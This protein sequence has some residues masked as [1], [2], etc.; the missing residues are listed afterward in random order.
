MQAP[1]D[2]LAKAIIDATL[3]AYCDVAL[4]E[5]VSADEL[6]SDAVVDPKADGSV[7]RTRG[8]LGRMATEPC[9]IEAYSSNISK[10][11]VDRCCARASWHRAQ[12]GDDRLLWIVTPG[13]ARSVLDCWNLRRRGWPEGVFVGA[14]RREP[15]VV[16]L[17]QL[18]RS[19][20]TLL[21][22]LMSRGVDLQRAI[23]DVG[24]LSK[25]CWERE[26]VAKLLVRVGPE[27]ARMTG[28]P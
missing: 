3:G 21:L 14:H 20:S 2:T 24:A 16:V 4:E 13:V 23:E 11:D 17:A 15:R 27:L 5:G 18:A 28:D 22:R 6:F 19:R 25:R 12:R 10:R 7:L 26:F 8:L 9:I 1:F